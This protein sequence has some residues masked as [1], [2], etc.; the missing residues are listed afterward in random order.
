MVITPAAD[1]DAPE[2]QGAGK[3]EHEDASSST[4][5]LVCGPLPTGAR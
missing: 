3:P 5:R 2:L 4:L 1:A